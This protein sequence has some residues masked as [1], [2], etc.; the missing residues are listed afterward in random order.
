MEIVSEVLLLISVCCLGCPVVVLLVVLLIVA[1]S[2]PSS[3]LSSCRCCVCAIEPK[4][5]PSLRHSMD[6][7]PSHKLDVGSSSLSCV[8]CVGRVVGSSISY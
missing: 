8:G 7:C 5:P 4:W 2:S 3:L 1:S 6:S